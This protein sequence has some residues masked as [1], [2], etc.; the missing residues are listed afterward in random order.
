MECNSVE[1]LQAHLGTNNQK[2]SCKL[3][4][5]QLQMTEEEKNHG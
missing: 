1:C 2:L 5:H 4:N 3:G